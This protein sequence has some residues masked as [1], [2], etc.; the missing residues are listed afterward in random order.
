MTQLLRCTGIHA[1]SSYSLGAHVHL[2]CKLS[3]DLLA[4]GEVTSG[5][6]LVVFVALFTQGTIDMIR[7]GQHRQVPHREPR[8]K[9]RARAR[10]RR[11][12]NARQHHDSYNRAPLTRDRADLRCGLRGDS[13]TY[14][15]TNSAR[16]ILFRIASRSTE[17][18]ACNMACKGDLLCAAHL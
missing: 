16:A 3:R 15:A 14:S 8:S 10:A 13:A 2:R 7:Q 17:L 6:N 11:R 1:T 5:A 18:N 4:A 12:T 9:H